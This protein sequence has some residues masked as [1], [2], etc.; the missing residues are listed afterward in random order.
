MPELMQPTHMPPITG[1]AVPDDFYWVLQHPAPLAGMPYPSPR[2]PWQDL[3]AAG[4]RHVVCLEGDGPAYDPSP[5]IMSHRTR[6]QDL[7]GGRVPRHPGQEERL[8]HQAALAVVRILQAG[9]GVVVHCVGG[10]GRTGTVIGCVLRGCGISAVEVITYLN[11]LHQARRR[12]GWPESEWQAQV[13]HRFSD[14]EELRRAIAP[15]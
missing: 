14:A 15:I 7:Y 8:I 3:A 9:D 13:V 10:T 12:F 2:T 5:L 11:H 1:L 4:F 6:L